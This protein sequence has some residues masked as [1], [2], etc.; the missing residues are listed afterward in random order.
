VTELQTTRK[1]YIFTIIAVVIMA[2]AAVALVYHKSKGPDLTPDEKIQASAAR[3]A[4]EAERVIAEEKSNA[5]VYCQL[6]VT[7]FLKA[8]STA[9]FGSET[10]ALGPHR[11]RVVSYV[12]AEN[13]FGA[14][15]RTGYTCEATYLGNENWKLTKLST[16]ELIPA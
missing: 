8:P 5:A 4:N 9:Q 6:Q 11:W 3:R 14:Q 13:S 7:H 1:E 12:D 15:L 10:V 2:C 16:N